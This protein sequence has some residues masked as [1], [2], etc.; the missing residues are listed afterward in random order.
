MRWL[1][2]LVTP[3]GGVI[4]DPFAGTGTTGAAANLEGFRSILIE[5]ETEYQAD[6]RRRMTL[7]QAGPAERARRVARARRVKCII[8]HTKGQNAP[9]RGGRHTCPR[10]TN[11]TASEASGERR[12]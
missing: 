4:L 7:T 6:I 12:V 5:R 9:G 1:C 10:P 3:P 8:L 2:R 11:P